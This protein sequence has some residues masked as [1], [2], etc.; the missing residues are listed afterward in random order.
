M[1][2]AARGRAGRMRGIGAGRVGVTHF[3]WDRL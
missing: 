3:N 2:G 1:N